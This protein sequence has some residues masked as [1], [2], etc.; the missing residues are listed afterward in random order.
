MKQLVL[1]LAF[2]IGMTGLAACQ[3]A[4]EANGQPAGEQTTPAVAT[5]DGKSISNEFFEFY[6]KSRAGK[7]VSEL[8]EEQKKALMDE[9]VRLELTA[10]TAV[11]TGLDK[12]PDTAAQLE[13]QRLTVLADAAF[14]KHLEGK[15]PTEQELRAEYETQVAAMPKLE[16]RARHILVATEPFAQ[17]VIEKLNKGA[18][19]GDL[20]RKESMDAKESGGELGWF[21]PNRMVPEFASAVIALKKGEITKQPVKT[22][23]GWHVIQLEETRDVSPPDFEQVKE[24]LATLV[25]QKKLQGYVDELKKTAKIDTKL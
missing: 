20:A 17:A 5:I 22:Q 9:I 25:Q 23:Y 8:N 12:E 14:K 18:D 21:S 7:P 19:F 10:Q 13:L 16:Y 1:T 11:K 15:T 24:R 4:G 6:A 3:K 2:A